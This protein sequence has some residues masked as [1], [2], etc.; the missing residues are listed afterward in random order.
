MKTERMLPNHSVRPAL[1]QYKTRQ[2]HHKKRELYTN[3]SH[4]CRCGKS[5]QNLS[6]SNP[7]KV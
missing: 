1:S 5:H 6:K 3:I 4:E 7:K 2:K